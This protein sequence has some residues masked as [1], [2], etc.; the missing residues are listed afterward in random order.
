MQE[1]KANRVDTCEDLLGYFGEEGEDFLAHIVT[2][3][4][5]WLNNFQ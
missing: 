5:T 3:E 4:E 1:L 2:G